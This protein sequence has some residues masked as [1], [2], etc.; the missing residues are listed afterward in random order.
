MF[1]LEV[2]TCKK[3]CKSKHA[4]WLQPSWSRFCIANVSRDHSKWIPPSSRWGVSPLKGCTAAV[5]TAGSGPHSLSPPRLASSWQ[6]RASQVSVEARVSSATWLPLWK[7]AVRVC[8]GI[9]NPKWLQFAGRTTPAVG[10]PWIHPVAACYRHWYQ[11]RAT[12]WGKIAQGHDPSHALGH[13][14]NGV[15]DWLTPWAMANHHCKSRVSQISLEI[16]Q[17]LT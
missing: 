15:Q 14:L 10:G 5:D 7:I 8:C 3:A 1:F 16:T 2:L 9:K 12:S 17:M 13:A 6:F 11:P 4:I